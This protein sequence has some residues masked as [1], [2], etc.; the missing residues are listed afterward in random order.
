MKNP[1]KECIVQSM[2]QTP[3]GEVK[4]NLVSVINSC[5]PNLKPIIDK[6]FV[7]DM[8]TTIRKDPNREQ[9]ITINYYDGP[10]VDCILHIKDGCVVEILGFSRRG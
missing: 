2:C 9:P 4:K 3:C 6:N 7:I 5:A 1:C 10:D 8:C